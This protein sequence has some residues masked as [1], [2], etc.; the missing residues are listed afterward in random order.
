MKTA[1]IIGANSY[2]ARNLIHFINQNEEMKIIGLYDFSDKQIDDE[3]PYSKIN[4]KSKDSVSLINMN[5]DI[6]YMFIGK[7]GSAN[8]FTDYETFIDINELALLNVISEYINQKSKAKIVFPSTRLIY[9][10]QDF[11]LTEGAEK[12]FKTIYALNK[13]ACEN[14]LRQYH[15]IYGINYCILRICVP[16]GT[17]I[18][19][20]SSYGTAE[21]M[22]N[23][24]I[25][26]EDIVLYGDGHQRRT[27]INMKDLCNIFYLAGL[28]E[29]CINDVFNV[30]GEDYSLK[31]MAELLAKKYKVK[32]SFIDWPEIAK[33]IE[34]G[35]TIF[36]DEKLKNKLGNVIKYSFSEWVKEN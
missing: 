5:C 26:G 33:K 28:S 6:I 9:K 31:E 19:S 24:A 22:L 3:I 21:F 8:G 13:F 2:I 20:A 27:L 7:T 1:I 29:N 4:I 35:S 16:Y 36:N 23:K 12:E 18:E 30:G 25:N 11:P 14:Y 34:S 10:G 17:M 32:I 15:E